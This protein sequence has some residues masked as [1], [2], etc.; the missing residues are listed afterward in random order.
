MH[1]KSFKGEYRVDFFEK[2]L[3]R[4]DIAYEKGDVIIT[5]GKLLE[6]YYSVLRDSHEL[7]EASEELKT[8]EGATRLLDVL[9]GRGFQKNN[10]LICVGGGTVQDLVSFVASILYRGVDWIFYPTTLLAQCDSCIGSKTSINHN[11][12]KNILGGFHPPKEIRIYPAFLKTLP[13]SEIKSGIGE[14]LHYLILNH[15]LD[16]AEEMV[17]DNNLLSNVMKYISAS[18]RI[19]KLMIERDEFD[20]D[21][22]NLFNYGHT[23]GH[24]I[25]TLSNYEVNH[26]QA[27]TMGMAIANRISLDR[28]LL[29]QGQFDRIEGILVENMPVF[30]TSRFEEYAD[31][32]RK[33]KKNT[34]DELTCILLTDHYGKKVSVPYNDVIRVVREYF[35]EGLQSDHNAG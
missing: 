11:G 13:D 12:F 26:G 31:I 27:V 17:S 9:T 2:D 35:N 29:G 3:A 14:M 30:R 6:N 19:K 8:L 34:S 20:K 16:L 23:F 22:R 25:E 10:R 24:A 15:K 28:G 5:D 21:E 7:V 32:L 33:D 1:I 18:L 4:P